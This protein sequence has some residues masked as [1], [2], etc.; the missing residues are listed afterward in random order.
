M[1]ALVRR[2]AAASLLGAALLAGCVHPGAERGMQTFGQGMANLFMAPFMIVAGLL[3][4]LAFL[5]YSAG[6]AL[7]DLNRA[8]VEAQVVSLNDAYRS[9]YGV[10]LDDPRVDRGSGQVAGTEFRFGQHRPNAILEAT[11]AFQ[12]LLAS[13]GMPEEKARHYVVVADYTHVR[14]R[15]VLLVAVVHRQTAMQPL[16]VVSKH[17]GI[18]TTLRPDH[19]GWA[20]AYARDAH[21]AAIDE[22]I[23]WV[24]IDYAA[25]RQ[26]RTVATLMAIAAESVKTGKRTPEYWAM[27]QRWLAGETSQVIA[28]SAGKVKKAI[29][30]S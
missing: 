15:G 8:M 13:L 26:D 29:G 10:R 30:L 18:A 14:T 7:D 23:D 9:A 16:R 22:V 6:I 2:I 5:P 1:K 27:E 4:G 28:E 19:A 12:R 11:D 3:Q 24:A 20:S 25:L 21:G 17:T